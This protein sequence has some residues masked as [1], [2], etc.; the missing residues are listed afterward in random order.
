[1][2]SFSS[3]YVDSVSS[4]QLEP[5]KGSLEITLYRTQQ[6]S[7]LKCATIAFALHLY[8]GNQTAA[9]FS[10]D[11]S[12]LLSHPLPQF[13]SFLMASSGSAMKAIMIVEVIPSCICSSCTLSSQ[14]LNSVKL[15]S[16]C[17]SSSEAIPAQVE[18][19]SLLLPHSPLLFHI[20]TTDYCLMKNDVVLLRIPFST[21]EKSCC[22]ERTFLEK[23]Q[24]TGILELTFNVPN[25]PVSDWI[26]L[27]VTF[28]KDH[29]VWML[30]S[31]TPTLDSH[32]DLRVG[33]GNTR[34]QPPWLQVE[35]SKDNV[36]YLNEETGRYVTSIPKQR[37]VNVGLF[38][39]S[40]E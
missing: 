17:S 30:F 22:V 35:S 13:S 8:Q 15:T 29:Y 38:V 6:L 32:R 28:Q 2:Y 34:R 37:L 11:G 27:R 25:K 3:Q 23:G 12:S 31:I 26:R 5:V 39:G 4:C 14:H 1:M 20:T 10:F 9:L 16:S 24:A 19:S 36:V 7:L 33:M 40:E 21:I 18:S